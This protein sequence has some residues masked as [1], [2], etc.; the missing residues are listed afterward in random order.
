MVVVVVG[1]G[2]GAG[3]HKPA[4]SPH[5]H[6]IVCKIPRLFMCGTISPLVFDQSLSNLVGNLIDFK[7]FFPA[8]S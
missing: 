3:G 4:P 7:A 2:G 6:T 1:W 8:K 5:R